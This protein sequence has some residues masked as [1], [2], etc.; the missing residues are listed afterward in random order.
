MRRRSFG[1]GCGG[2]MF[3][4]LGLRRLIGRRG[5][6]WGLRW[7]GLRRASMGG[8]ICWTRGLILWLRVRLVMRFTI[9]GWHLFWHDGWQQMDWMELAS[10]RRTKIVCTIGPASESREVLGRMMD[11]GMNVAR[12]NF[13]HGSH[14]EHA[15][16]IALL[17]EIADEKGRRLRFCR[18]W[19]GRKF[20]RGV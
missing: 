5:K 7:W 11:A 13:S 3:A 2:M 12:L 9:P 8:G 14:A 4:C 18:I 16:K 19:R 10:M 6:V 15:R 20:A 17:R 1:G